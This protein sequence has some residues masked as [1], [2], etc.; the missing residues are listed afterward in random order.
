M[1]KR[2]LF[3]CPSCR[4]RKLFG[5]AAK[6]HYLSQAAISQQISKLEEEVEFVYLTGVNTASLTEAG[7]YYYRRSNSYLRN[8]RKNRETDALCIQKEF[9]ENS[10]GGLYNLFENKYLPPVLSMNI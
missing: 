1:L 4:N 3:F 9:A 6:K 2:V 5:Q 7:K 10:S 8:M